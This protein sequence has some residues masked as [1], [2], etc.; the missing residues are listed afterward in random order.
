MP[1]VYACLISTF[2]VRDIPSAIAIDN[3][4]FFPVL[5]IA[6][7]SVYFSVKFRKHIRS[8]SIDAK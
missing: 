3:K 8:Q 7:I 6:N 4:T 1:N 5:L 2:I